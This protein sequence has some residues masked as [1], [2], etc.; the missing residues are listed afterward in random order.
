M[1]RAISCHE[2]RVVV[3]HVQDS[4]TGLQ[5][6][7]TH[8]CAYPVSVMLSVVYPSIYLSMIDVYLQVIDNTI[9]KLA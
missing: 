4:L 5:F 8:G 6:Q 1:P 2:H 3:G 7:P 9:L